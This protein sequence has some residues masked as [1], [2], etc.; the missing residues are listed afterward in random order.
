MLPMAT[1]GIIWRDVSL[2]KDI[3][4]GDFV[5]QIVTILT[6]EQQLFCV[7]KRTPLNCSCGDVDQIDEVHISDM[8]EELFEDR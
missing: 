3:L 7:F 6:N 4:L 2:M 8:T 1:G 5:G